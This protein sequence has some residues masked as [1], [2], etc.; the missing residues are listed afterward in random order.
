MA[1]ASATMTIIPS[2]FQNI[3]L[4]S[5]RSCR[6]YTLCHPNAP[7]SV[8]FFHFQNS[9][10]FFVRPSLYCN[11]LMRRV[12]H[13]LKTVS[14]VDSGVEVS[15]TEPEDLITVKD[16]KIVVESQDEDKIQVRV[17][18]TGDATQRVF[19]KVLTN[20]ARSAPPIPGFRREKGGKTT[21]VPRDFLIQILGEER[22]GLNVKDKKVTTTQKA[23]ELR[24]SFSPGNEFGFSAVLELEKS[25]VE[26]S[27]TET[28]SSSSSSSD[29]ENDEVPVS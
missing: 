21:K 4:F 26:E 5:L 11:P 17:D 27:E 28:S 3:E 24:K 23:E 14:A 7:K 16:A 1:S 18:L 9:S 10:C 29:E 13:V 2:K 15:I 12:Q 6:N 8:N 19:D 25:E 20:L 22:E